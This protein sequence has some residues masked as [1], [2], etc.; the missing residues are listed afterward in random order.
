[1]NN[2]VEK[3]IPMAFKAV[4]EQM[5][6]PDDSVSKQYN[7]YI[8]SFGASVI[9]SGMPLALLY[10]LR[11]KDSKGKEKPKSGRE[12]DR[13]PMMK[14]IFQIVNEYRGTVDT[15]AKNLFDYYRDSND[16]QMLRRQILDAAV[17]IKLVIRTYPLK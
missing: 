13:G 17:A 5:K 10:N 8:S 16:Q 1:M 12:V 7:G 11:S 2:R 15:N 14:A 6:N 4:N 3:M 9:Q